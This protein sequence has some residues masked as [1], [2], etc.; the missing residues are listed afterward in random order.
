VQKQGLKIRGEKLPGMRA[1]AMGFSGPRSWQSPERQPSKSKDSSLAAVPARILSKRNRTFPVG[2]VKRREFDLRPKDTFVLVR[3][4]RKQR[5]QHHQVRQRKQPLFRLRAGCFG[6]SRDHA[7]VTAAREVVQMLHADA[8]QAG[9]FR[10]R[11][12]FLARLNFYQGTSLA[13]RRSSSNC[14]DARSRLEDAYLPCNS[15]SV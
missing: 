5:R 12:N 13:L 9:H 14:F 10:V 8:R 15:R 7:Q 2:R 6:C 3:A 11:E 4:A 1:P